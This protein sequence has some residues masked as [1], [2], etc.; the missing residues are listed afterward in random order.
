MAIEPLTS[1]NRAHSLLPAPVGQP[2]HLEL[3]KERP[4]IVDFIS[5]FPILTAQR[6]IGQRDAKIVSSLEPSKCFIQLVELG[7]VLFRQRLKCGNNL[8]K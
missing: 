1:I 4:S 8:V 7:I 3:P 5:R 2:L 6:D